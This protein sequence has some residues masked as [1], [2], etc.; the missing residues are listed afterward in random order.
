MFYN[1]RTLVTKL[2]IILIQYFIILWLLYQFR[3]L[4]SWTMHDFHTLL[5]SASNTSITSDNNTTPNRSMTI[6]SDLQRRYFVNPKQ[7]QSHYKT[8]CQV[9]TAITWLISVRVRQQNPWWPIAITLKSFNVLKVNHN[10]ETD[11]SNYSL[12]KTHSFNKEDYSY[13][14]GGEWLFRGKRIQQ[15]CCFRSVGLRWQLDLDISLGS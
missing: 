11:F 15:T 2:Y 9:T 10:S 6:R 7:C 3:N 1:I 8:Q 13:C 14:A 4:T 5:C 12:N